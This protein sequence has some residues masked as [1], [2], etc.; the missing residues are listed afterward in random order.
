MLYKHNYYY[1]H[2]AAQSILLRPH[3]NVVQ[4]KGPAKPRAA[5]CFGVTGWYCLAGSALLSLVP[6]GEASCQSYLF[7]SLFLSALSS[8]GCVNMQ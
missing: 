5:A 2:A 6:C 8:M 4:L 3:V 1:E 7:S